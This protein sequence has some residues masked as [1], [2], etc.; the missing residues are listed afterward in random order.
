MPGLVKIGMTSLDDAR[1]RIDQLYTTGVPFPFE[2]AF[3]CKVA[4][5]LE[6]ERALHI[7]FEPSRLNP[8][9]EFFKISAEQAIAILKLLH[10][11]DASPDL[12]ASPTSVEPEDTEAAKNFRARRP[13]LNFIEMN[14]PIG[15][16]LLFVN[17]GTSVQ[18]VSERKIKFGGEETSLTA[19][20]R[21]LLGLPYSVSPGRYW[22]Y[23]GR[24]IDE[25]YADTYQN[26]DD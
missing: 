17:G 13:N 2:I 20:T 15:S 11:E 7:A 21:L 5:A 14:I 26:F 4:N 3:V 1:S 6:V 12:A 24:T 23:N 22:T 19:V 8:K 18:V 9:R 10:V 25:I 16:H